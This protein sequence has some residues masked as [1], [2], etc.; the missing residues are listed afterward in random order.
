MVDQYR[1]VVDGGETKSTILM[2]GIILEDAIAIN[3]QDD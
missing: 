1:D 2:Q 3:P